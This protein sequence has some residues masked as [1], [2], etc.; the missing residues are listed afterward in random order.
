M[1]YEKNKT[2]RGGT[3][4]RSWDIKYKRAELHCASRNM[5]LLLFFF[6]TI[7]RLQSLEAKLLVATTCRER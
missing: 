1:E 2:T 7:A 3:V 4:Q 6:I 5:F